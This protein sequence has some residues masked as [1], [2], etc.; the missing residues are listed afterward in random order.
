M[1]KIMFFRPLFYIGGTEMAILS[2]VRNLKGYEIYIG[3]TDE[4]S[5]NDLLNQYKPYAKIVKLDNNYKE[6]IDTLIICSPYKL[7]LEINNLIKRKK[8]ILWFHHFGNRDSSIFLDDSFYDSVDEVV[9]VSETCK[10]ALLK[11]EYG[12][13]LKGKVKVIYNIIDVKDIIE[14]SNEEIIL[15]TKHEL[16]LVS[17]GRVC[18]EKGFDRQLI[19]ANLLKKHNIDF[20]WYIIGGNY[21]NNV[22]MEIKIKYRK[23][24][25]NFVFTGFLNNPFNIIKHCDYLVLL[26]DN[27]TWGLV[28]T[29]AKILGVPCIVTDFDVA[30]EQIL[31]NHTGIILSKDNVD[32]YEDKIDQIINNKQ[33]YK[34]NLKE[35][36]WSNDK[37][38]K[39]WNNIL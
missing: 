3:Y 34:N 5:N 8:T 15:D 29:E 21:Y 25:D 36:T 24:K 39:K 2:L 13:R 17:V 16:T 27:E 9:A 22:E 7:A 11:Q 4:T 35:F 10:K 31:D 6:E 38:I 33:I 26:S 30:Y 37:T 23:L 32:S 12:K 20:K 14:K 28:I 1:K 19:L 18:Y